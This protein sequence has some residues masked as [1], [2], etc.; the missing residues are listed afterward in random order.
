M[1]RCFSSGDRDNAEFASNRAKL[2]KT[3]E[4][5]SQVL[6]NFTAKVHILS[7]LTR[8]YLHAAAVTRQ[9]EIKLTE[10]HL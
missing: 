9:E 3:F 1:S 6:D 4:V 7:L 10:M 2:E 8:T 5:L